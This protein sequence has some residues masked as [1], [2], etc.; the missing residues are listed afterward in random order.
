MFKYKINIII[1]SCI[2]SVPSFM[3]AGADQVNNK[4]SATFSSTSYNGHRDLPS[5]NRSI[6]D[7]FRPTK[8]KQEE[9]KSNEDIS[10]QLL[11]LHNIERSR[12]HLVNL[13]LNDKL[14]LAA[15]KQSNDI[16][17]RDNPNSNLRMLLKMQPAVGLIHPQVFQEIV[18]LQMLLWTVG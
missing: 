11:K 2:I 13:T 17:I 3:I 7:W 6:L 12:F 10:K 14:T 15:Q 8:K 16:A 4:V 1:L 18:L 9:P 5:V